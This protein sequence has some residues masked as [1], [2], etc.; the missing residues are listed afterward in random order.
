MKPFV[1]KARD[2]AREPLYVRITPDMI[3]RLNNLQRNTGINRSD[4]IQQ[5]LEYALEH[6]EVKK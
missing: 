1:I 3:E 6:L 5:A 2:A 4:I